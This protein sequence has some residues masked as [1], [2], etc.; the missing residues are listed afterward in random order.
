M[1]I[2]LICPYSLSYYGGVQK[3]VLGL[4]SEFKKANHKV[5]IFVP[6]AKIGENYNNKDI[7]LLGGSLNLPLE[8]TFP[9]SFG[10]TVNGVSLNDYFSKERFDVLHFHNPTTPFLPWQILSISKS[11]NI[12]T[13]HAD[14]I[15]HK[16]YKVYPF[17]FKSLYDYLLPKIDGF[18]AVSKSAKHSLN[19]IYPRAKVTIIP[20]GIDISRFVSGRPI[21]KFKDDKFNLLSVG[22]L[23]ER[24]GIPYL[25]SALAKIKRI[26]PKSLRLILI[27]DGPEKLKIINQ[28]KKLKIIKNVEMIGEVSEEKLPNFYKTADLFVAPA[29]HGESFGL[30]LLE[31]M[32][33][34]APIVAVANRGYREILKKI[35]NYSLVP[36][37]N[38]KK[39]A[40]KIAILL[41]NQKL[42]EKLKAWGENEVQ[43]YSWFKIAEKVLD[44]YQQTIKRNHR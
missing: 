35:A 9:L 44:F 34:G 15:D 22:R 29:T 33:A 23:D 27:G 21:K 25:L 18:I 26:L 4:Y 12:S 42:R 13:F 36:P 28:I 20:N 40:E 5:K 39:L 1:K 17:L 38:P 41:K 2:G 8:S 3:H 43:K 16:I 19:S 10:L 37:R 6:K 11:I 31:A 32:A 7:I 30:V 14:L 24:K